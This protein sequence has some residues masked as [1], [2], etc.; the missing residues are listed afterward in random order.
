[1]KFGDPGFGGPRRGGLERGGLER[2]GLEGGDPDIAVIDV[3]IPARNEEALVGACLASVVEAARFVRVVRGDLAPS[4]R[5][6]LVADSCTDATRA[7]SERWPG[8]RVEEIAVACVGAA[9]AHGVRVA[10]ADSPGHGRHW[11]AN[12]DADSVVPRSWLAHQLVLAEAGFELVVGTVR[13]TMSELTPDQRELWLGAHV[14]GKPNG[15]VH[16]ANL[17]FRLDAYLAAGG[18]LD[19]SEHEDNDLVDRMVARGVAVVASDEAEVVTSGRRYG[20]TPG[21]YAGYLRALD[22]PVA[23]VI[24]GAD[25][26]RDR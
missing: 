11:I 19:Q 10:A 16:G 21:G 1:M 17:G 26:A 24:T 15:H 3:V 7:V 13:P 14:R 5:I 2:G 12:T 9:R 4:I 25:R 8:V 6:T 18:Y 23:A 20:R 22:H